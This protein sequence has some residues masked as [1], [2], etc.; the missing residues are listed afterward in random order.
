VNEIQFARG[1][2]NMLIGLSRISASFV[3]LLSGF[4]TDRL[5]AKKAMMVLLSATGLS[6]LLLGLFKGPVATVVLLF[7]QA[8][9]VVCLFPIGFTIISLLFPSELRSV[10]VALIIFLGF[11]L[12][13]GVI[14]TAIGHWAE[15]FSFSSGFIL[16]GLLFLTLLPFFHRSIRETRERN[17]QK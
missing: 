7:L 17:P 9:S 15:A 1:T 2:A 14:P 10:A 12:G 16:L 4:L 11:L 5:G 3:L 8:A 6:I 13:G